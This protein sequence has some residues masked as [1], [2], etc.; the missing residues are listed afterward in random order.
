MVSL[1]LKEPKSPKKIPEYLDKCLITSFVKSFRTVT[2]LVD[3]KRNISNTDV[4]I[5]SNFWTY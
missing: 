2:L 1:N 5:F 4:S 3:F